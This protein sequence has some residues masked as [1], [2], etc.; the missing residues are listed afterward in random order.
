MWGRTTKNGS[1]ERRD[2]ACPTYQVDGKDTC[3]QRN[4]A[5]EVIDQ[6]VIDFLKTMVARIPGFV[7]RLENDVREAS[8]KRDPDLAKKVEALREQEADLD[9]Q[10][11]KARELCLKELLSD[12][13]YERE[14]NRIKAEKGLATAERLRLGE[15]AVIQ[16]WRFLK[17]RTIAGWLKDLDGAMAASTPAERRE[18]IQSVVERVSVQGNQVV[19]LRLNRL[20][21]RPWMEWE[22]VAI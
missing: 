5:C 6:Q 13:E 3:P 7:E 14:S 15:Q 21:M 16:E 1:Y 11:T 4:V 8:T 2:Y 22:G 10:L 9:R 19:Q 18:F 17:V 20:F 12:S